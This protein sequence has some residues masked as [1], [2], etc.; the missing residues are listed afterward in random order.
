MTRWI[1]PPVAM[2]LF[3]T[4]LSP[5]AGGDPAGAAPATETVKIV[6]VIDGKPAPGYR[7]ADGG[8]GPT[9]D[10]CARS[11]FALDPG[12]YACGSPGAAGARACWPSEDNTLLCLLDADDHVLHRHPVAAPPMERAPWQP[13]PLGLELAGGAHCYPVW[14]GAWGASVSGYAA[15]YSCSATATDPAVLVLARLGASPVNRAEPAWTVQVGDLTTT[16]PTTRT[17]TRALYA[18]ARS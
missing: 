2:L 14:G 16:E 13:A 10:G 15:K 7:V 1:A 6:A 17:V 8:P 11:P 4:L 12:I 5:P 18:A 9:L 3:A